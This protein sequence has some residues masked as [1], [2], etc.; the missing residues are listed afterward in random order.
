MTGVQTCAL[1]ISG[2]DSTSYAINISSLSTDGFSAY[3]TNNPIF[4]DKDGYNNL[5]LSGSINHKFNKDN[6]INLNFIKSNGNNR[7]D[8]RFDSNF[9][10]RKNKMD[11]QAIGI[12]FIMRWIRFG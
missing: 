6:S 1:P 4:S 3:K 10:D 5:S 7:Y 8:N 9:T 2:N 11:T 12:N